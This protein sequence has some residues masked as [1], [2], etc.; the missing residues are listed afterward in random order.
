MATYTYAENMLVEPIRSSFSRV[1]G[2]NWYRHGNWTCH[3]KVA[4][5]AQ[6][7]RLPMEGERN[8]SLMAFREQI[9]EAKRRSEFHTS[10]SPVLPNILWFL[11]LQSSSDFGTLGINVGIIDRSQ[12]RK[13]FYLFFECSRKSLMN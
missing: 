2:M 12:N 6:G 3:R 13:H 4:C 9:S 1:K 10:N 11:R 7:R 8:R 5:I